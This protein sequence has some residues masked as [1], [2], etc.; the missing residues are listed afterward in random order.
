MIDKL[1]SDELQRKR[2]QAVKTALLLG[3]VALAIFCIFVG[4]AV[5]GR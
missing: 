2:A 1:H 4:A 3:V 5:L